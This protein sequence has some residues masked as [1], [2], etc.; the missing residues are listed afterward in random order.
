MDHSD[1]VTNVV[2]LTIVLVHIPTKRRARTPTV[3]MDKPSTVS[4]YSNPSGSVQIPSS[5]IRNIQPFVV[6]KKPH[7]MTNLYLDPIKTTN[8]ESDVIASAKGS[9]VPKVM[10]TIGKHI[11]VLISQIL[12]I[13][14][15]S[16]LVSDVTT[17]LAQTNH[18]IEIP[19]EKSDGKSDSESVPIKSPEKYEEKDDYDSMFVDISDKEENS[20]VKKDQSTDI[21]NVD[22]LDSDDEPIGKRLA[23]GIVKRLK[24]RKGK[25][26]ESTSKSPKAPKKSRSVGPSK[27]WSKVVTPATKK[28]SLKRKEVPS[29]SS[30]SDFDVE[31]N[32][33]DIMPI[34]KDVG[35]KV[36]ANVP[37]V[38]IDN[39]FFNS[40][41]NVEKW[42]FVHQIRSTLERELG[43]DA[44]ECAEV[45]D[46]IKE[47]GLMKSVAGFGKCYEMLVK[48]FIVNMSKDC[49][50]KRNKKFRKVYVIG[51]RVE[52]SPE[53]IN[54][55]MSRSEEEQVEVEVKKWPRKGKLSI[56]CLSVK[57]IVLHRV[58]AANWVP[59][60]HTSNIA[61][62]LGKFIYIVVYRENVLD[63]VTTS[64]KKSII[65][66]YRIGIIVELKDTCKTLD[67]TIKAC[68]E[69]KSR[70]VILINALFE[71]DTE[72][73]LNGDKEKYNE[74]E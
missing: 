70:F 23:P 25:V 9:I 38:P 7:S 15:K 49:D 33:Q 26:V 1:V 50:N 27:G 12:G 59:T 5:E 61:T 34:K 21:V 66:T 52:F 28:R 3:K 22:Y 51:K 32:V 42:K 57:Y 40:V 2:P 19:L 20:G 4:K 31:K 63:I 17:S 8:I 68:T 56:G 48:E 62:W 46:L 10:D 55:F 24:S 41:E 58:G 6:V 30:D 64:D 73:N 37:E 74:V 35:K 72:G 45:M 16:D 11:R 60:S 43:K 29:S 53:I 13:E 54:R 65:S 67:E 69:K 47:D 71:E 18:P 44:F 39:I 36:P 14:P